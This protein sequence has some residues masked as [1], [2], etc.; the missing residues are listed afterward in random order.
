M[1]YRGRP[2]DILILSYSMEKNN[3]FDSLI[4][5]LHFRNYSQKTAASYL[6]YNREL[7]RF[8]EKDPREVNSN[9][10]KDY[11]DYLARD[12][13]ASTVS[14]AYNA[15]HFYYQ[16]IWRRSFFANIR[17]P[18]Q[19]KYLPVVLS[20]A[21]AQKIVKSLKNPKH[22]CI[23]SLLYGTGLRVSELARVR[24]RDIDLDRM[25]LR[26]FQGKGKKDRQTII[27]RSLESILRAQQQVK[28]PDSFL[29]TNSR[30]DHLTE[31]SIQKIVAHA[32]SVAGISKTVSPHTLRHSFATHLLENGTDIRYIQELLG[33]AKLQTTQIYTHV[34]DNNLKNIRSPL[35]TSLEK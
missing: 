9:D 33:H 17:Q 31:A 2:I 19:A 27:P 11:L 8:C 6:Y 14:V 12:R 26:V 35:D 13:S 23:V 3:T 10:I 5:E 20:Q 24:M 29:F 22:R 4:R 1:S 21:E 25:I 15:I 32:A 28:R 34:A 7:L 18:R 30:G 16:E